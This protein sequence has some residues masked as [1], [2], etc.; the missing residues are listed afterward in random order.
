[1]HI[2]IERDKERGRNEE[3]DGEMMKNIYFKKLDCD[4]KS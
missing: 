1:M 3:R 4:A 2:Y